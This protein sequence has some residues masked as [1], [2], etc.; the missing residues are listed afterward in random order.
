[1]KRKIFLLLLPFLAFVI[2]GLFGCNQET[3]TATTVTTTT[4]TTTT[5]QTTGTTGTTTGTATTTVP[6]GQ[7]V[8]VVFE[9]NDGTEVASQT[10]DV[11]DTLQSVSTTREDFAFVGWYTDSALENEWDLA[12]DQVEGNMTLYAKWEFT[13]VILGTGTEADP[14]LISTAKD[15]DVVRNGEFVYQD[16]AY[17]LQTADLVIETTFADIDGVVF[18]GNFDGNAFTITVTGDSGVFYE[19]GGNIDNVVLY[20][21][22]ETETVDSIGMLANY[23][24]GTITNVQALGEGIRSLVGTVG[25]MTPEL[26]GAGAIVGTNLVS[27]LIESSSSDT[28]V[29]ARVGGGGIVGN[30]QGTIRLA[31][32]WGTVGEKEVIYISEAEKS[33]PKFSY[34]G[35]IAGFNSGLVEQSQ[36]RG[37]VF[38]QRAGNSP[39][40]PT[41]SNKVFGG[42]VGYN[43]A[44]GT[45]TEC[46]NA[47]GTAGATV[48]ADRIVGG[49]VGQNFGIVSYSYSPANIGARANLGGIVGLQDESETSVASVSFSWSNSNFRSDGNE[50]DEIAAF[51]SADVVNWYNVA[52]NCDYCY[53]HGTRGMAPTGEGNMEGASVTQDLTS[54]LNYGLASGEEKW[55]VTNG[56]SSGNAKTK[57]VWQKATMTFDVDGVETAVTVQ[58]GD[59]PAFPGTPEKAGYTFVEWRTDL[60]D[61]Q[62]VWNG[63]GITSNGKV[64]A[65]FELTT[66]EIT[67]VLLGGTNSENNPATYTYLTPTITLEPATRNGCTFLGWVDDSENTV[68]Q[69]ELNSVG[70]KTL[71]A[72][73]QIDVAY[74]TLQFATLDWPAQTVLDYAGESFTLIAPEKPGF[75]FLGWSL[76]G[77][78]VAFTADQVVTY[79]DMN[80]YA[81]EG[82]VTLT[83]LFQEIFNYTVQF[84]ANGALGTMDDQIFQTGKAQT[85]TANAFTADSYQFMGWEYNGILYSDQESVT[86]LALSGETAVL[87]AQW[88]GGANI[89]LNGDFS[90]SDTF[91]TTDDKTYSA[92]G[93]NV[94]RNGTTNVP[95]L[96]VA[97]TDGAL[98]VDS[99]I[100][101][102]AKAL[103]FYAYTQVDLTGIAV[104]DYFYVTF[105]A[106]VDVDTYNIIGVYLR[107]RAVG[108]TT[109]KTAA[110]LQ[111]FDALST[112]LN[113]FSTI[114]PVDTIYDGYEYFL[115]ITLG[116]PD[117]GIA[118]LYTFTID[119]V[120]LHKLGS[121]S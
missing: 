36:N 88:V 110:A 71:Y 79:A 44:D 114:M 26:G 72:S 10:L 3:T 102:G 7:S 109:F 113:T 5:Q 103:N 80:A 95:Q 75:E 94:Y 58:M 105:D 117:G 85:L 8:T 101:T 23:N 38:A 70:N 90:N 41:N 48:H 35:G 53:Y 59:T 74:V 6:T 45:V 82:V 78:T 56:S 104:G 19:N 61:G 84:D 64:Y 118:G 120:S 40:D 25:T 13:Y 12:T 93:W 17:F 29:Q 9:T 22:I 67:Y 55:V 16:E 98:V 116:T 107:A 91:T 34:M 111:T 60:G 87:V 49:I 81:V 33:V 52:K 46:Y 30:N 27:G 99:E 62:T 119:N 2:I 51:N 121:V 73:W 66:F 42:I 83:P 92:V 76:D 1:M 97:I 77:T 54:V 15:L 14:Y 4:T 86:D 39:D 32:A 37:R 108:S 47:Y 28:N 68:T 11:G 21:D 50:T 96:A 115:L 69:I 89:V 31:S 112:S 106:S 57:L 63:G 24:S 18:A 20:G 43:T 100:A 65:Y